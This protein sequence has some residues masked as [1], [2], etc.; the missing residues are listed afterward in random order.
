MVRANALE[1]QYLGDA[2]LSGV[3]MDLLSKGENDEAK[4]LADTPE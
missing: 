3:L 2:S 4:G 1:N